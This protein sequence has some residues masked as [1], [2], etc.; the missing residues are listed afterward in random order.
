MRAASLMLALVGCP[1][2]TYTP[3]IPSS[4]P[5]DVPIPRES[6]P[7]AGPRAVVDGAPPAPIAA[8]LPGGGT[9]PPWLA[10]LRAV[11]NPRLEV[12][13]ST[14]PAT[15]KTGTALVT[16]RIEA[17]GTLLDV[18]LVRTSGSGPYDSCLLQAFREARPKP[19]PP[20]ALGSDGQL[21]TPEMAF[22]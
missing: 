1:R 4:I 9:L 21:V 6:G 2:S 12:C 10:H 5:D 19:P 7:L 20:D 16:A 13:L 22:R 17:D 15:I 14:G 3:P 18:T 11:V 8:D